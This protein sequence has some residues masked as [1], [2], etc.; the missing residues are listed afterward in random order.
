M[1]KP[2]EFKHDAVTRATAAYYRA[3]SVQGFG[4]INQPGEIREQTHDEKSYVTLH[5]TNGTLAVYRINN[6]GSLRALKR[7]PPALD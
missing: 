5:N 3:A 7:W 2:L 1:V 4:Q 6:N